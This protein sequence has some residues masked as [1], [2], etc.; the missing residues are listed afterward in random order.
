MQVVEVFLH[1][2]TPRHTNNQRPRAL[3]LSAISFY[4]GVLLVFQIGLTFLVRVA[5]GVLGYATNITIDDLL[6]NT[7]EQRIQQGAPVISLNNEL[8]TAAKAKAE[9]M[10]ANQYWA[11]TSPTGRDPWY[12]I[13]NTGYN[14]LYAGENLARDFAD[15]QGVVNAWMNSPTHKENLLNSRY[16]EVGFAVVNGKYNGYETTLVV[17][18][19]G[20]KQGSAPTV[21]APQ[22]PA[23]IVP[24]PPP[25]PPVIGEVK[26]VKIDLFSLTKK[27]SFGLV[28]LLMIVLAIDAILVYRRRTIR[29]SGHNLAHMMMLVVLLV[30]LNLVGRG[31]IL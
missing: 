14:Y 23:A 1:L 8:S 11:H 31:A 9:D 10:F 3:H 21:N 4:I 18:V 17:Q 20:T 5:P 28:S 25:A 6:K 15:S 30:V 29:I 13:L 26:S 16:Q 27:F 12:F 22:K 24:T 7:N 19:L 2:F